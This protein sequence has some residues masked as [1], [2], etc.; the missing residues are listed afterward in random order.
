MPVLAS[1]TSAMKPIRKVGTSGT[2]TLAVPGGV[3]AR[4][5]VRSSSTVLRR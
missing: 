5:F 4:E 1:I 2:L 3:R